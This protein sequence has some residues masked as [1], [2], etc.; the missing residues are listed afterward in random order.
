[1]KQTKNTK[2][3]LEWQAGYT[4][5]NLT[6][7]SL[8]YREIM[9]CMWWKLRG[10]CRWIGRLTRTPVFGQ[11]MSS[12]AIQKGGTPGRPASEASPVIKRSQPTSLGILLR[13]SWIFLSSISP[14][15]FMLKLCPISRYRP[16]GSSIAPT[17]DPQTG[18]EEVPTKH[19]GFDSQRARCELLGWRPT[20]FTPSY[21]SMTG[22]SY[23]KQSGRQPDQR[24]KVLPPIKGT[25]PK[26]KER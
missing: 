19:C 21:I 8:M 26:L 4:K 14:R 17:K 16:L 3:A 2:S 1:M 6:C 24:G 25:Y 18:S 9:P 7:R 22:P 12:P 11:R 23:T 15:S 20:I 5:G 13:S 10:K